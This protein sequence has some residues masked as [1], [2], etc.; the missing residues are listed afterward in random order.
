[1]QTPRQ[2]KSSLNV[3][4]VEVYMADWE[5]KQWLTYH[6]RE[7]QKHLLLL[8]VALLTELKRYGAMFVS[9]ASRAVHK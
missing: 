8:T 2:D 3:L 7:P 9:L 5:S 6:I 1:M 4:H